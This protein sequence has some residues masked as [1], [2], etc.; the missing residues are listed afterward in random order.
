[1]QDIFRDAGIE[2]EDEVDDGPLKAEGTQHVGDEAGDSADGNHGRKKRD[3][4]AEWNDAD[5]RASD[6]NGRGASKKADHGDEGFEVV[7]REQR[8]RTEGQEAEGEETDS[9]DE[10]PEREKAVMRAMG[11]RMQT[12]RGRDEMEDEAYNRWN[13]EEDEEDLP[14]WFREEERKFMR[15]QM[16]VSGSEV[17]DAQEALRRVDDKPIKK[18]AEARA[19][20]KRHERR[21]LQK[22]KARAEAVSG[23]GELA[24]HTKRREIERIY[25]SAMSS[26]GQSNAKRGKSRPVDRRMKKDAPRGGRGSHKKGASSKPGGSRAKARR[27]K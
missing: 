18:V 16:P 15:P 21:Q 23:S 9:A 5:V 7:E 8:E 3:T 27:R 20:R 6:E 13:V 10:L 11:M 17:R 26:K 2:L 14:E 24:E 19:R 4:E 1:M 22:A 25:S 12:K